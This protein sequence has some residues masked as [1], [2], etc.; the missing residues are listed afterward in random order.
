[1]LVSRPCG[2]QVTD[3]IQ[4]L[5]HRIKT[6]IYL[7]MHEELLK[8]MAKSIN[9]TDSD[10]DLCKKHFEPV[11]TQ[12][13]QIIEEEGKI[14]NH[15]YFV[16]SGYVR[17]FH[18]NDKGDEVTTHIN[19]PPGFITSYF[20]FTNQTKANDN[21]ECI[22]DCELLRITKANLDVLTEESANF[23]DFSILAF[24]QSLAYNENR[25]KELA[26]LTAEERYQNFMR[27]YPH[28]LHNVPLKYIASFLG[29]NPKSL[30]R[31]R[32]EIIK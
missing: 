15:L 28:I 29:M 23:K 24:Q 26:T 18:F 1:M 27:N 13:G 19:C 8:I 16:V 30:S 7:K 9:L 25:S 2:L 4:H 22:T 3:C 31:I 20:H 10:R 12:K 11:C 32:K 6:R 5:I 14:P 21:L 17:L